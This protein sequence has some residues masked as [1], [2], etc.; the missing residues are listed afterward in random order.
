[1][2]YGPTLNRRQ[3]GIPMH[4]T[5]AF[6]WNTSKTSFEPF[7]LFQSALRMFWTPRPFHEW[8]NQ[9]LTWKI[10]MQYK[11]VDLQSLHRFLFLSFFNYHPLLGFQCSHPWQINMSASDDIPP[12]GTTTSSS[13]RV[14]GRLC[15]WS[16]GRDHYMAR[17]AG[18]LVLACYFSSQ[19]KNHYEYSSQT[20]LSCWFW[21][22]SGT[23]S[24][25]AP[26]CIYIRFVSSFSARG[27]S[28]CFEQKWRSCW[29]YWFSNSALKWARRLFQQL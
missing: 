26:I 10:C 29:A 1:M 7:F 17:A 24:E 5:C 3:S 15:I 12:V 16:T 6:K 20:F 18:R 22:L 2:K 14:R 9:F 19:S 23:A 28:R 27:Y 11:L 21:A 8:E 13:G 25:Y 4:T